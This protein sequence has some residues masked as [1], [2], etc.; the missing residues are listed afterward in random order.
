M[1][2][3]EKKIWPYVTGGIPDEKF[4]RKNV[5][6]TKEEIRIITI[7]K[8]RIRDDSII[9]DIGAGTGAL[10]VEAA[11]RAG[12]GKVYAV[13]KEIERSKL[14][15]RNVSK[16]NLE[17]VKVITGEAPS[18]LKELPPADRIII[19]G[20]GGKLKPILNQIDKKLATDGRIVINAVTLDTL[21]E[22]Y[23]LFNKLDYDF[24]IC[25]IAVTRG[26]DIAGYKMLKALNPVYI[27]SGEKEN[28][29]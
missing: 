17:N 6:M 10:T 9:Y 20:S 27:I 18:A 8:L 16:F 1:K 12:K 4:I 2:N 24:D 13:E 11:I 23:D 5:P 14:I 25:N 22:I 28:K 19:G 21:V 7:S 15:A 3:H 29:K 26:K